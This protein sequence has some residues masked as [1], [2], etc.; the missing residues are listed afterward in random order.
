M[1]ACGSGR[2]RCR[3]AKPLLCSLSCAGTKHGIVL[4]AHLTIVWALARVHRDADAARLFTAFNHEA[5]KW[6]AVGADSRTRQRLTKRA[7]DGSTP[8]TYLYV[9]ENGRQQGFH[10][11]QLL[12][13]PRTKAAAFKDWAYRCLVRLTG[14]R[15]LNPEVLCLR[16][17]RTWNEADGVARCWDWFRYVTKSLSPDLHVRTDDRR[18]V[19]IREIFKP[20]PFVEVEPVRCAQLA[21]GSRNIWTKAQQQAGFQSR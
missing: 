18:W 16:V 12:F 13:V 1:P 17:H 20:Y 5:G 3:R 14:G 10:T 8:H 4:N 2:P 21:S 15:R 6:L 7:W 9:H 19:P 11:H